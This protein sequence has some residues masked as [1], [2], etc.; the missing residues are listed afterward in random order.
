[1]ASITG[2]SSGGVRYVRV[3]PGP[4]ALTRILYSARSLVDGHAGAFALDVPQSLIDTRDGIVENRAVA[5]VAVDRGHLP[6][7]FDAVHIGADQEWQGKRPSSL[8]F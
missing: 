5:P 7:S 1:M 3:A 6:D 2:W 4:I 8:N